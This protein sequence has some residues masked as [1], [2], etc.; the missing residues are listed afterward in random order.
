MDGV[1]AAIDE[2]DKVVGLDRLGAVHLND[3]RDEFESHRDRHENIGDGFI[4]EAGMQAFL[5]EPRFEKL[6]V[7]METPGLG[8][9][10][11]PGA[12][13]VERANKFRAV[14]LKARGK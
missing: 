11:G 3:S 1:T 4:G 8:E 10:K 5:S 6:P 9:S 14:G 2:L 13:D 7:L 12:E